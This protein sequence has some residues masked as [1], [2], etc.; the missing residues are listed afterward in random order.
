MQYLRNSSVL[1]NFDW[2]SFMSIVAF[3]HNIQIINCTSV[4]I[5]TQTSEINKKERSCI[6]TTESSYHFREKKKENL[7]MFMLALGFY[8]L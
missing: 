8:W 4:K 7:Q 5:Y 1:N 3:Y 2:F 6:N